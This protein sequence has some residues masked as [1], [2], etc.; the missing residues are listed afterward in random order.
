MKKTIVL[1]LLLL[2][3]LCMF[4]QNHNDIINWEFSH[5][6][7]EDN[8]VELE[9]KANLEK[10]WHLYS[11]TVLGEDTIYLPTI[12][13]FVMDNDTIEHL[14]DEQTKYHEEYDDDI[15]G[16]LRY[17]SNQAIFKQ[18]ISVNSNEDFILSG[19]IYYQL[20]DSSKCLPPEEI[21]FSFMVD[22]FDK[23]SEEDYEEKYSLIFNSQHNNTE[24]KE[25]RGLLMLFFLAFISGFAALL[26]PC[27]FPMI[28]MTVSF[29]TKQST[30][31][32]KGIKNGVLYGL[33]IVLIY[34]LLGTIVTGL[35]GASFLN[36]L[37]TGFWANI[38]FFILIMIFAISFLGAFE[39][40]LPSSWI[41]KSDKNS[42]RAGIIGIFFMAFTLALVSFSCTGPIVGPLL[43]Q[44]ATV[45]GLAPIIGMLGFSLALALPFSL[46]TIFPGW[47]NSLPQSGGWLNTVKVS[48]GFLE[49][50]L[51]LK[52]LSMADMAIDGHFLERELF[53]AIWIGI[54]LSWSLYLFGFFRLPHDS[55]SDFI[56][57]SRVLLATFILIFTIYLV[58]GMWGAPLKIISGFDPPKHSY[59]ESPSG[60][61]LNSTNYDN[62]IPESSH[63]GPHGLLLFHDLE[64]G[65][66]FAK[67]NSKPVLLDFTGI[68]CVN[69]RRMENKVWG[70]EG[71]IE[72]L[73][74]ELVI[75]S[76]EVDN[77]SVKLPLEKQLTLTNDNGKVKKIIT[78][79]DKYGYLQESRY[80]VQTQPY[81]RIVIPN[82][83]EEFEDIDG[84]GSADYEHHGN[85]ND[86]ADWL[87]KGIEKYNNR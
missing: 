62:I 77:H 74:N 32:L 55:K 30:D 58:P 24:S 9:F 70:E 45:G 78:V 54:F 84:I 82:D 23:L 12:F 49:L 34:V 73:R 37:A 7:V 61:N 17:F 21:Y 83:G 43:V 35:F 10:S 57:V 51:A 20:C 18:I 67:E 4:S 85:K 46:F 56:S 75:I 26:T 65:L 41:N 79:G 27:V 15:G 2:F 11:Q 47:M 53:L 66:K 63:L 31:K 42:D 1:T 13:S 16:Y 69:C 38:F 3:N 36:Q 39:I 6:I 28:P 14:V 76:L 71:V 29:F 60:F 86:F 25:K 33:C 40:R 64:K 50:A 44:S 5:R 81:Y 68:N 80:N 19:F 48:L 8:K 87:K 22:G 52:F 72:I 59:S